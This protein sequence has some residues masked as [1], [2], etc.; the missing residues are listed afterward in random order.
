MC[1]L[2]FSTDSD[3]K[4]IPQTAEGLDKEM[5]TQYNFFR[6]KYGEELLIDLIHLEDLGKYIKLSPVQRLSY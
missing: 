1:K 5:I 2:V 4:K 6:T 3:T